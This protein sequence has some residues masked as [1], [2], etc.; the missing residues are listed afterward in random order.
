[1]APPSAVLISDV[2]YNLQTLP[3]ADRAMRM[4]IK[5]ANKLG[6]PLVVAGDLHDTKANIR[7]ECINA[8]LETFN[9]CEECP[10]ILRGNHDSLNE[11]SQEHSLNF[12]SN[13]ALVIDDYHYNAQ[14]K[15]HLLAYQHNKED[16]ARHLSYIP[17]GEILIMHQGIIGKNMGDYIQDKSAIDIELIK[18]YKV[19]SGHYHSRDDIYIGNPFTL[20]YGEAK[21]PEKGFKILYDDG[22]T[23]FIPTDIRK[24]VIIDFAVVEGLFEDLLINKT[25][26]PSEGDLVWVKATLTRDQVPRLTKEVIARLLDL[27]GPFKLTYKVHEFE[28]AQKS[29]N[30]QPELFDSLIDRLREAD[31]T[32]TR[33]KNLWRTL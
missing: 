21:D 23:E 19:H 14:V 32:K 26:E 28:K 1:M 11:K 5:T 3:L 7:G 6:V 33:L 8:M 16:F 27:Q 24:H 2:H 17:A 18:D 29:Y 10:I 9:L 20:T 25:S 30:S 13:R 31:E 4:A 15:A 22:C 12:L